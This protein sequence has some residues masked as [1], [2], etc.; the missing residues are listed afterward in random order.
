MNCQAGFQAAFILDFDSSIPR[1]KMNIILKLKDCIS[2]L[3][4]SNNRIE[5]HWVPEHKDIE[6]KE[7]DFL[8]MI[9]LMTYSH[10][11]L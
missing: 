11:D 6:G 8:L 2:K 7:S 9:C 3:E 4:D 10:Q 1:N 5:V